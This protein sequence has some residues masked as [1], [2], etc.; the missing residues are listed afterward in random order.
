VHA[1]LAAGNHTITLDAKN[2]QLVYDAKG[3][4]WTYEYHNT[5]NVTVKGKAH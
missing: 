3:N 2:T 5:W 1:P 4:A